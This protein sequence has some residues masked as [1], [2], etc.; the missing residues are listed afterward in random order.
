LY[1]GV[2]SSNFTLNSRRLLLKIPFFQIS[3]EI[4]NIT[5]ALV[6]AVVAAAVGA[7]KLRLSMIAESARR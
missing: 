6:S 3:P 4:K 7:A 1:S 5:S 2:L